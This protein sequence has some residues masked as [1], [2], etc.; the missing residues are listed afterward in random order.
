MLLPSSA[1]D[2]LG[3]GAVN[4]AGAVQDA[5]V[6]EVAGGRQRRNVLY[7]MIIG[8]SVSII[9]TILLATASAAARRVVSALYI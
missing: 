7:A 6:A 1:T 5:L 8:L 9:P 3:D 4:H 2:G